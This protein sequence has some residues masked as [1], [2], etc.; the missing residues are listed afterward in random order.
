MLKILSTLFILTLVAYASPIQDKSSSTK[1]SLGIIVQIEGKAKL[2][3]K[4]SIKKHKA[5]VGEAL[6]SG[7]KLISY[8][9]AKI[10]L[11]LSD[12]SN[13]ILNESSEIT[14]ISDTSLEQNNG[15]IYYKIKKRTK[16]RG[17]KVKTPFSIIG[18]KGTEFIVNTDNDGQIALNEGLV[19]I[20]SLRADFELHKKKIMD[21]FEAYKLKQDKAFA[22]YKN[23]NGEEVISYVKTFDLEASHVLNFGDA[24]HCDIECESYVTDDMF[25]EDIELLFSEYQKML[26]K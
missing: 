6:Y 19:A 1:T 23:P 3:P 15:E 22:K 7:D 18:I 25:D 2:L 26:E 10:I 9:N 13:I 11:K 20:E 16:S 12:T 14:M 4:E 5:K 17:L 21:E 8:K 24:S